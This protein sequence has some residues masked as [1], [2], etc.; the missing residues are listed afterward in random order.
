MLNLENHTIMAHW[1]NELEIL[2][3]LDKL[4]VFTTGQ[5]TKDTLIRRGNKIVTSTSFG[6]GIALENEMP[7]GFTA[8][9]PFSLGRGRLIYEDSYEDNKIARRE[10]DLQTQLRMARCRQMKRNNSLTVTEA[11]V[12]QVLATVPLRI[13]LHINRRH[14]AYQSV[15]R[16]SLGNIVKRRSR[17]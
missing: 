1:G 10:A 8:P 3:D 17:S 9:P 16:T 6:R 7:Y 13:S 12:H 4:S 14:L 15:P 11:E 5:L 2:S